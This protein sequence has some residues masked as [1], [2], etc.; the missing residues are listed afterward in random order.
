MRLQKVII[1]KVDIQ[2]KAEKKLAV[3]MQVSYATHGTDSC[4]PYNK[5]CP[6]SSNQD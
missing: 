1:Q 2:E 5:P 3:D 6:L 4:N